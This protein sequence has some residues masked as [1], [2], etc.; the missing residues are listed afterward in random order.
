MRY[1]AFALASLALAGC[2]ST[3]DGYVDR[4]DDLLEA[5]RQNESLAE[6][7]RREQQDGCLAGGNALDLGCRRE[8]EALADLI[9]PPQLPEGVEISQVPPPP[10]TPDDD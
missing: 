6:Q 9:T 3:G 5:P 8:R 4:G 1:I 7:L 2:A 10:R